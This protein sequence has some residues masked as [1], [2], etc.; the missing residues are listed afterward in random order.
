MYI[1]A[2]NGA[3]AKD[4][5]I[6]KKLAFLMTLI[7]VLILPINLI[8]GLY[9]VAS[10][11]LLFTSIT[12]L[13]YFYYNRTKDFKRASAA[14]LLVA[15]VDFVYMYYSG[16]TQ[17]AG[18]LWTLTFPFLVFYFRAY[19]V[20]WHYLLPYYLVLG[21]VSVLG[22]LGLYVLQQP[23]Y[24]TIIFFL[25]HFVLCVYL[26]II[27][28]N[29]A[30]LDER[31]YR[32]DLFYKH[33]LDLHCVTNQSETLLSIN[34]AWE[35]VLGWTESELLGTRF[36]ELLHP[37]D[38]AR[39]TDVHNQIEIGAVVYEF[40]NRYRCKDG[41]YR[42]LSW[43]SFPGMQKGNVYAVARDVTHERE[44][45]T[46]VTRSESRFRLLIDSATVG[47]YEMVNQQIRVVNDTLL[48]WTGSERGDWKQLCLEYFI[49][50]DHTI[51]LKEY[52]DSV[53]KK[54]RTDAVC[55]VQ[56]RLFDGSYLWVE[57]SC[58]VV[59]EQDEEILIGTLHNI[60]D[61]K[62]LELE[63]AYQSRLNRFLANV[64]FL[65]IRTDSEAFSIK[66]QRM[67]TELGQMIGASRTYLFV[68]DANSSTVLRNT[69]EW[70]AEGVFSVK[71]RYLRFDLNE[72]PDFQ[73]YLQ[74]QSLIR[75][76]DRSNFKD[77]ETLLQIMEQDAIQSMLFLPMTG[78]QRVV[79]YLGVDYTEQPHAF[80]ESEINLL[81]V[82]GLMVADTMERLDMDR[83]SRKK[84]ETLH[85][86]NQTKDKLF[87]IIAHD[88]RSPFNT[89]I[90]FTDLMMDDSLPL[91]AEEMRSY[92]R[93]LNQ[94]AKGTLDLLQNLLDW[95]RLQR[96]VLQS[97]PVPVLVH[98]FMRQQLD[99]FEEKIRN[100]RLRVRLVADPALQVGLDVRMVETLMRNLVGNAIKFTPVGGQ[101]TIQADR[102]SSELFQ[103]TVQD[104]GMGIPE[105][106][107]PTLFVFDEKKGRSGTEGEPSS[108]LG[109][110]ICREFVEIMQGRIWVESIEGKGSTFH[111]ELPNISLETPT[112]TVV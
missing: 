91:S 81:Q 2:H 84:A 88:L 54:T 45:I 21:L 40:E 103:F 72:Y 56:L 16:G 111:V 46:R 3:F 1:D 89:F 71:D 51:G 24:F 82:L 17:G 55:E 25:V 101:I 110:M 96:G 32:S 5:A 39:T 93:L 77:S 68:F 107:L 19:R 90:G 6:F 67:L 97:N 86:L 31:L 49:H 73:R 94:Q 35:K 70:V 13:L 48:L 87:S 58:Q 7:A 22:Y 4:D 75:I 52:Y 63:Q 47:I 29:R 38:V 43:R 78:H 34:P 69:H 64:S 30:K 76:E 85:N 98:A 74:Y 95:S 79:G 50:P 61:R 105:N 106:M 23:M 27:F 28:Q 12:W 65:F 26:Y 9:D 99:L 100:K 18:V 33:S 14:V 92:A 109:L 11:L 44:M 83:R 41:S 108:G 60:D 80:L 15:A 53:R 102:K 62:K 57:H 37:E 66:L 42:H 59:Y 112:T 20:A 36:V 104:T 8:N 10:L